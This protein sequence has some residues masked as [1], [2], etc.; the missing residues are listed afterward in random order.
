MSVSQAGRYVGMGAQHSGGTW[1]NKD[2]RSRLWLTFRDG[3]VNRRGVV[4]PIGGD[5]DNHTRN[6]LQ[7]GLHHR[8]ITNVI[9]RQ[10]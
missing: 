8:K 4:G 1:R 3:A 6:L 7:Q 2:R 10:L 5:R 9:G